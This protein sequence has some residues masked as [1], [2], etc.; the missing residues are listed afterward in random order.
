MAVN[1]DL[2]LWVP[3]DEASELLA[4]D[5][6]RELGDSLNG[7]VWFARHFVL[8]T[9]PPDMR[10]PDGMTLLLANV[11]GVSAWPVRVRKGNV[12]PTPSWGGDVLVCMVSHVWR[13]DVDVFLAERAAALLGTGGVAVRR[14]RTHYFCPVCQTNVMPVLIGITRVNLPPACFRCGARFIGAERG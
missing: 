5:L 3:L 9:T 1:V 4:L 6:A 14:G 8:G 12:R 13:G 2:E 10:R 7:W 11:P